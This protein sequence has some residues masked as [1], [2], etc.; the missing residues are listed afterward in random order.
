MKQSRVRLQES[1]RLGDDI[2]KVLPALIKSVGGIDKITL[3]TISRP[4]P[5]TDRLPKDNRLATLSRKALAPGH[6]PL[7]SFWASILLELPGHTYDAPFLSK[8]FEGTIFHASSSGA[9][10]SE[11]FATADV[12]PTLIREQMSGLR[13]NR[14]LALSSRVS[15]TVKGFLHLPLVDFAIPYSESNTN[16]IIHLAEQLGMPS[17]ILSTGRSYHYYG[18]HLLSSEQYFGEFLGRTLLFAPLVDGRWVAHQL[19]DGLA[20]LRVSRD[21]QSQQVPKLVGGA[22]WQ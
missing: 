5:I 8:I 18:L 9:L 6:N 1:V 16:I 3:L 7:I 13:P 11:D 10:S 12:T 14:F 2:T 17:V 21:P 4:S 19:I 15:T 20:T 22:R